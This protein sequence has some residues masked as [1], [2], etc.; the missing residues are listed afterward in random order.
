MK[1]QNVRGVYYDFKAVCVLKEV[2][3]LLCN[4]EGNIAKF[5]QLFKCAFAYIVVVAI[6]HLHNKEFEWFCKDADVYSRVTLGA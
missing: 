3:W 5:Q 4:R 2:G 1:T 6:T